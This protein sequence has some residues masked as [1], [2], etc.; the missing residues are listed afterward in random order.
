MPKLIFNGQ[1]IA[2]CTYTS[3]GGE[4]S[5]QDVLTDGVVSTTSAYATAYYDEAPSEDYITITF[6]CTGVEQVNGITFKTSSLSST[7][8]TF[9]LEM[10][11]TGSGN[12]VVFCALTDTYIRTYSYAGN[13]AEITATIKGYNLT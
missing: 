3:G 1:E 9:S 8:T 5:M 12:V 2:D 11:T 7:E 4:S 13:F 10:N 6:K